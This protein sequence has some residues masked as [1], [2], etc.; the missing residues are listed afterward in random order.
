MAYTKEELTKWLRAELV[1]IANDVANVRKSDMSEFHQGLD[2]ICA[3]DTKVAR[4]LERLVTLELCEALKSTLW[5]LKGGSYGRVGKPDRAKPEAILQAEQ[6][7]AKADK[8]N[9]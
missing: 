9:D 6:V 7:L 8:Y 1:D 2:I 3:Y 4:I 5:V